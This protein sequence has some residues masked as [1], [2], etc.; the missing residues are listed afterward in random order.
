[1]L[2][3]NKIRRSK[4]ALN[5]ILFLVSRVGTLQINSHLKKS[6]MLSSI[7]FFFLIIIV[8]TH[9]HT[10]T[11]S[12]TTTTIHKT[13][14][15]H[16]LKPLSKNPITTTTMIPRFSPPKNEPKLPQHQHTNKN[17]FLFWLQHFFFFFSIL[18]GWIMR[19]NK[20]IKVKT[21]TIAN[22]SINIYTLYKNNC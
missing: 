4:T 13:L 16:T 3:L 15:T 19:L 17:I 18:L 5:V 9:T 12:V 6:K 22:K 1:M 11:H 21:K 20:I 10:Y 14:Y 8:V 7:S 2:S